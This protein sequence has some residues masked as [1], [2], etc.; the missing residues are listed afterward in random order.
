MNVTNII[1]DIKEALSSTDYELYFGKHTRYSSVRDVKDYIVILEPFNLR[2][3]RENKTHY[4]TSFALWVGIRRGINEEYHTNEGSQARLMDELLS[5]TTEVI[6]A[7][8]SHSRIRI[9]QKL[10]TIELT[11]YEAD[12]GVTANSQAFLNFTIPVTIW[13]QSE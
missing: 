10:E 1:A 11:Y 4:D 9:N 6:E 3:A 8:G 7:I 13:L 2:P 5:D 12:G